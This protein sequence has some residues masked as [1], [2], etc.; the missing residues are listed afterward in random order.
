MYTAVLEAVPERV[1]SSNL[2]LGTKLINRYMKVN[3]YLNETLYK[4]IDLG[5]V[6][7]YNPKTITDIVFADK[8]AGVIPASFKADEA[9]KIRIEKS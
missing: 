9:M 8:D 5:S 2:A 1:A 3:I 4:T 7:S 6:Q